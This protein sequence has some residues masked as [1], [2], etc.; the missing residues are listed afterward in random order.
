MLVWTQTC[1]QWRF[2]LP[3]EVILI[4]YDVNRINLNIIIGEDTFT[5]FKLSFWLQSLRNNYGQN[6]FFP[7]IKSKQ[8]PVKSLSHFFSTLMA[9]LKASFYLRNKPENHVK[10]GYD[11]LNSG[12]NL[13][14]HWLPWIVAGPLEEILKYCICWWKSKMVDGLGLTSAL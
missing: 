13:H 5:T 12:A 1:T 8:C 7:L 11:L 3:L 4:I 10:A 6:Y 14:H 9:S 2:F